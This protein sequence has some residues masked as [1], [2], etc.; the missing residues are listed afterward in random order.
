MAAK[1]TAQ[2]PSPKTAPKTPAKA[3]ATA[4]K[5]VAKKSAAKPAPKVAAKPAKAAAKPAPKAVATPEPKAADKTAVAKLPKVV[6]KPEPKAASKPETKPAAQASSFKDTV[7]RAAAKVAQVAASA[8]LKVLD[9]DAGRKAPSF[10]LSDETGKTVSSSSLAGKP[11]LLYF[12]PKDDTPGCT[13]EACDIRDSFARFG[14]Q[15]LRVLGVSPDSAQ[16]HTKFIKKYGL[17][18]T[19]LSDPEKTLASAYG[20]WGEKSNYG[21][22][23]LGIIRSTFLIGPDGTIKKAYRGVKVNGHVDAVLADAKALL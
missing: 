5:A 23:Y 7:K 13:K 12:Y 21:K 15:G 17:P 4:P 3:G 16:S 2:K 1:K 11:Y 20:V 22:K 6:A 9:P 19:L 14:K 18:F 8:A 10:E